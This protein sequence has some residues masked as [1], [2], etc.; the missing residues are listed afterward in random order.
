MIAGYGYSA[1]CSGMAGRVKGKCERCGTALKGRQQRWCS[2]ACSDWWYWNHC[3]SGA[4][5]FVKGKARVGKGLYQC[6]HCLTEVETI[7]I[8]H[9]EPCLGKHAQNGCW[10][11]TEG[12]EALCVPCHRAETKRQHQAGVLKKKVA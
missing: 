11:H 1:D 7:E 4:K 2:Q 8:N 10:H 3:W 9:R 5:A 12:L 6:A